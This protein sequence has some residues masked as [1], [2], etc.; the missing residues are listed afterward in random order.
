MLKASGQPKRLAARF[1]YVTTGLYQV[2]VK[3]YQLNKLFQT[4]I[5]LLM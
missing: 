3:V 1:Y 5:Q 4:G 2:D